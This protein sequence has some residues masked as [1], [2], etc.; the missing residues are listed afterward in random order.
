M[1]VKA[2]Y[3]HAPGPASAIL[4]GELPDP[5]PGPG[6]ALVKVQAVA[7]NHIDTFVRSGAYPQLLPDPFLIG[8]D[9][10][11]TVI[12]LG[13]GCQ[14]VAVGDAVW[15][16]NQGYAGRQGSFAELLAID[17]VWLSLVPQG[18]EPT[19]AVAQLHSLTTV[20]AGLLNKARPQGGESLFLRGAGD[21]GL[22]AA[23]VAKALG[24]RVVMTAGSEEKA[25]QCSEAGADAVI[26]YR[27]ESLADG[28][29]R[30]APQG[31]D[32]YWDLTNEPDMTLA[33]E[34]TAWRGRLLLMSGLRHTTSLPVGSFYTRN[35]TLHGFT[36]TGL[37]QLEL[38]EI[39]LKINRLLPALTPEPPQIL[40][41]SE[42]ARAHSM[43]EDGSARGKLVL[44]PE[45][46]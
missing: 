5:V 32:I 3:I 28:L 22:T 27:D 12:A 42:A 30:F 9:L 10:V 8:R 13:E 25:Q 19:T 33:V 44:V 45:A 38:Q 2:A 37:T 15:A 23:R 11:G 4:Y 34:H 43:L 26:L 1:T 7:V 17:E 36:V 46:P 40:P 21:V 20:C 35:L 39:A 6:Q 31:V 29:S 24:C 41:L 14:Q 18:V 16:N